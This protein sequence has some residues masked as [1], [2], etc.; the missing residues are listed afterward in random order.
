MIKNETAFFAILFLPG[1]DL[2]ATLLPPCSVSLRTSLVY[3][4]YI[5]RISLEHQGGDN[6]PFPAHYLCITRA[7]SS[8]LKIRPISKIIMAASSPGMSAGMKTI[9]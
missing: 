4:S 9:V 3:P 7:G 6:G 8:F 5:P 1:C 2:V